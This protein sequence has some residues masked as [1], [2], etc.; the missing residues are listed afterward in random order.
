VSVSE[1]LCAVLY[2]CVRACVCV[3]SET[4]AVC[5]GLIQKKKEVAPLTHATTTVISPYAAACLLQVCDTHTLTHSLSHTH[6][7]KLSLLH[8]HSPTYSLT[9]SFN[10]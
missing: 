6:T 1:I 10:L 9:H 8:T 2:A 4:V 3:C 5:K 7:H